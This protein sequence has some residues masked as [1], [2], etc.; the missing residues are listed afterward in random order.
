MEPRGCREQQTH[1]PAPSCTA[2]GQEMELF[3]TEKVSFLQGSRAVRSE[4]PRNARGTEGMRPDP[5]AP[6]ARVATGSLE[7]EGGP[8]PRRGS[9]FNEKLEGSWGER[10]VCTQEPPPP[11]LAREDPVFHGKTPFSTGSPG[12]RFPARSGSHAHAPRALRAAGIVCR[13]P[14]TLGRVR[15]L[16]P[17]GRHRPRG[18]G[19]QFGGSG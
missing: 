11:A 4:P 12:A 18:T 8:W 19:T 16:S 15:Q 13:A 10:H 6:S 1:V 9:V 5:A 7:G 14:G 17:P 3:S 2:V